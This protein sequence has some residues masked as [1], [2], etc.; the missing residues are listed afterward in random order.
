MSF[1]LRHTLLQAWLDPLGKSSSE[2]NPNLGELK[3]ILTSRGVNSRGW[4][5]YLDYG[6]ALFE[7]LGR[8]WV[9]ADWLYSSGHNAVAFLHLLQ[10][11]EMDVLPPRALI[12]SM[13]R[14]SIP[15]DRLDSVPPAFFRAAWKRCVACEYAG[16]SLEA[17]IETDVV[18]L[19]KW[20]FETGQH[21]HPDPNQLKA[22]WD[23]IEHRHADWMRTWSTNSTKPQNRSATTLAGWPVP[24]LSVESDGLHF[25]V[26]STAAAL[27]EEG[28]AME[29]CIGEYADRCG[30]S[31]LRAYSVR[32]RKSNQRVATLTVAYKVENDHW[33]LK[34]IKG[35]ANTEVSELIIHAANSLIL[36]LDE[37]TAADANSRHYYRRVQSNYEKI[38]LTEE[39]CRLPYFLWAYFEAKKDGNH[40]TKPPALVG[41]LPG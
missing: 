26:L 31:S 13:G 21:E 8:P 9:A 2:S 10:S 24:V 23:A 1:K 16:I 33:F 12:S 40:G 5:L 39:N 28:K 20:Y 15:R 11:C 34:E 35:P 14:W 6:D 19:A 36:N 32:H 30:A 4:R 7:C 27:V 38:G 17:Y 18:P 41:L 25:V 37:A 3:G 22:G 29:H